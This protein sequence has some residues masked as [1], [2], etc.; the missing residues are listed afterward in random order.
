MSTESVRLT[1]RLQPRS[2]R[3]EVVDWNDESALR[4]RVK[5]APVKGAANE[6]LIQLLAKSLGVHKR[7]I[8]LVAGATGRNKIV[9][10]VGLSA[11]DLRSRL[12][13]L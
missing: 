8:S 12:T 6:D 11:D 4:V 5:A 1:V 2:S 10:I 3:D 9:E 7:D 13:R